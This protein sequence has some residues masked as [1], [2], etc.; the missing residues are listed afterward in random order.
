MVGDAFGVD[1]EQDGHAVAGLF[2]DLGGGDS[3]V[4]SGGHARVPELVRDLGER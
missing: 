2:G 3:G 4:Q 1:T